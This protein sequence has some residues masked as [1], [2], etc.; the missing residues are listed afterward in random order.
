MVTGIHHFWLN[1]QGGPSLIRGHRELLDIES[2]GVEFVDSLGDSPALGFVERFLPGEGIPE[3]AIR[4]DNGLR[5]LDRINFL[6]QRPACLQVKKLPRDV[7]PGNLE[8]TFSLPIGE[9]LRMKRSGLRVDQIGG[10]GTSVSAKQRIGQ[11][12]IPP[13]E[14]VQMQLDQQ[15]GQCIDQSCG[16]FWPEGMGKHCAVGKRKLQVPSDERRG[17]ILACGAFSIGHNGDRLDRGC[18]E[19]VE[20]AQQVIFPPGEVCGGFFHRHDVVGQ[21]DKPHHM[22]G[23]TFW[24]GSD[25]FLRPALQGQIPGQ[26]E[27]LRAWLRCRDGQRRGHGQVLSR[28]RGTPRVGSAPSVSQ[29]GYFEGTTSRFSR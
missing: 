17:K 7:H 15:Q 13:I 26:L 28:G 23:E 9:P 3:R 14:A 6:I 4:L 25:C 29:S 1:R 5:H 21:V 22:S 12:H 20:R 8:V 11:G 10:K 19:P 24:Q 18:I 16:G 2:E 27:Q